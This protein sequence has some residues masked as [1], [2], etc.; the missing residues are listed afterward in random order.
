MYPLISMMISYDSTR[1]L[2]VTKK[3]DNES[4][5]KMY[6]LVRDEDYRMCFEEHIGG[7]PE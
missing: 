2:T 7:S 5:I 4:I 6:S 3:N 1:A